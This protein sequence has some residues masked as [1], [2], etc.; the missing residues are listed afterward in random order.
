MRSYLGTSNINNIAPWV[1]GAF[2]NVPA[3]YFRHKKTAD[4]SAAFKNI[5][6]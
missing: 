3:P 6:E 4:E 5:S 1:H 2:T